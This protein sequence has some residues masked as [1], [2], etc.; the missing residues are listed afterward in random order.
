MSDRFSKSDEIRAYLADQRS[1]IESSIESCLEA[2]RRQDE[3]QG[4]EGWPP[5]IAEPIKAETEHHLS[6]LRNALAKIENTERLTDDY[7]SR[8]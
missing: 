8:E 1:R 7:S 6:A 2:L 4:W 5:E 3:M